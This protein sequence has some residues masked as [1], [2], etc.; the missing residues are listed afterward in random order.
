LTDPT[1]LVVS[2]LCLAV[3]LEHTKIFKSIETFIPQEVQSREPWLGV[4]VVRVAWKTLQ[5]TTQERRC[6]PQTK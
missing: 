5:F 3:M 1:A 6:Q 2:L 4:N